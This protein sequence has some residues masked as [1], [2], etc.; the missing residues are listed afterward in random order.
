M[1]LKRRYTFLYMPEDDRA[2]RQFNLPRWTL[3]AAGGAVFLLVLG[4]VLYGVDVRSGGAWRPGGSELARR[5]DHLRGAVHHLEGQVDGV[6]LELAA[7]RAV[8]VEVASTVNLPLPDDETYAAGIGG[9]GDLLVRPA[10]IPGTAAA[11]T[12]LADLDRDLALML[13]RARI[14]QQ[15]YRAMLDT[16]AARGEARNHIPSIRPLDTGWLSSRFGFRSDPFTGKQTFHRGLDFSTPV[17]TAVRVAADGVVK[18]VQTQRGFGKVLK[19]DH[20]DGVTTVYAHLD[21]ILVEKGAK[22]HRGDVVARSGNTGR[23]SAPHLHYEV[24]LG[25]R[26]VNPL[27]YILDSY[28]RN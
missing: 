13:R 3:M 21:R 11:G 12:S 4:T 6:R 24:R 25:G 16:L 7:V 9:R 20:G 22:V 17:G 18:A 1:K 27:P 15:G 5:N 10:E 19:I 8:Q 28:A 14:Q 2:C 26:P 23:S